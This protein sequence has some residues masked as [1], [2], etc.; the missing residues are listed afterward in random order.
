[1]GRMARKSRRRLGLA[2]AGGQRLIAAAAL[3]ACRPGQVG[4]GRS[5][6]DQ[7]QDGLRLD[8]LKHLLT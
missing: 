2:D 6:T 1:M 4:L 3:K 5:V 7:V 8:N